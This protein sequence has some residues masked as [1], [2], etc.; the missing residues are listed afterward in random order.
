[1]GTRDEIQV[2]RAE[3][4]RVQ[5]VQGLEDWIVAPLHWV[6]VEEELRGRV[7][8]DPIW[9]KLEED[10]RICRYEHFSK[11]PCSS[12][13]LGS[14]PISKVSMPSCFHDGRAGENVTTSF[15]RTPRLHEVNGSF[16]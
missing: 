15:W 12:Q 13:C 10:L 7:P 9:W 2:E 4:W 11:R 6:S 3:G 8:E 16:D 5:T 14:I 1:M